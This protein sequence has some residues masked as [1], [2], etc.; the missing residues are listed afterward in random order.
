MEN[1]KFFLN[2]PQ[3]NVRKSQQKETI[4]F[5][6]FK[7]G[8]YELTTDKIKK[9]KR[10]KYS[11]GLKI[12][13]Y[14]WDKEKYRCKRTSKTDYQSFNI[15]LENLEVL[16]K[17]IYR[18]HQ[19]EN[20]SPSD[21]HKLLVREDRNSRVL[22]MNLNQFIDKFIDDIKTGKRLTPKGTRYSD[23]TIK[24]IKSSINIFKEYLDYKKTQLDFD[25]ITMQVRNDFLFFLTEKDYSQNTIWRVF[26][27]LKT[28]MNK[29]AEEELHQNNI[30]G[31][32]NFVPQSVETENIYL[33]KEEIE[34]LIKLDL[35]KLPEEYTLYRDVFIVGCLIGQRYSDYHRISKNWYKDGN[36]EFH[37][38]K[39][40]NK[41]VIPL[42][43]MANVIL[44][45]YDYSFP[46][47]KIN[48][49][50]LNLIIKELGKMAKIDDNI[51]VETVKGGKKH[52]EVVKKYTLITSHTARRS[53]IT[54]MYLEGINSLDIM[55]ISGHKSEKEFLKYIKASEKEIANKLSGH[56]Y[57]KKSDDGA[58]KI[59]KI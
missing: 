40:G 42:H 11:T 56:S 34:R 30:T 57:F 49:N 20:P 25:D 15:R 53:G 48:Q 41:V 47:K 37:Q 5:L 17:K 27:D 22:K 4:V 10:L 35:T 19:H 6:M 23:N 29:A 28:I 51:E 46:V 12:F 36:L 31:Y 13:P 7:Y 58:K 16:I 55:S 8:Y 26:K 32:N 45:K 44:K 33:T 24:T 38:K 52:K 3:N 1:V 9:Y 54:N 59:E 43:Y 2:E 50:D 14:L 21:L 18:L 39:T